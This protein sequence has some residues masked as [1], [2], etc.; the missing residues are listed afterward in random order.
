MFVFEKSKRNF[1]IFIFLVFAL[2]TCLF[3]MRFDKLIIVESV[4][5]P[6]TDIKLIQHLDGGIIKSILVDEGEQVTEG[7]VLADL[8]DLENKADAKSIELSLR[9]LSIENLRYKALIQGKNIS[10][11]DAKF[12]DQDLAEILSEQKKA[13]FNDRSRHK[14]EL[15]NLEIDILERR[16]KQAEIEARLS[17]A[18]KSLELIQEQIQINTDLEK[19]KIVSRLEILKILREKSSLVSRIEEDQNILRGLK[20]QIQ[21]LSNQKKYTRTK[22]YSDNQNKYDKNLK[23]IIRLRESLLKANAKKSRS[24]IRSPIDGTVKRILINS[25]EEVIKPGQTL[26]EIIAA[27][28]ELLGEGFLTPSDRGF[29]KTNMPVLVRISGPDSFKYSSINGEV[30]FLSSDAVNIEG[31]GLTFKARIK[32]KGRAFVNQLNR[33]RLELFPGM[34]I[35]SAIKIGEQNLGEYLLKPISSQL[36]YSFSER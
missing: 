17:N 34:R 21:R 10:L 7:Q 15:K 32:I 31:A 2:L 23:D 20:A 26:M 24:Q 6:K 9:T 14:S 12:N 27:N 18:R 33:S 16:A 30:S 22:F 35:S 3:N 11:S 36:H 28:D 13:F 4:V 8:V 1:L 19:E 25:S 29:V 5:R